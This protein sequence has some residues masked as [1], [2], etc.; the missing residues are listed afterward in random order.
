MSSVT[1][2]LQTS[3]Q[4]RRLAVWSPAVPFLLWPLWSP[5]PRSRRWALPRVPAA[6]SLWGSVS[7]ASWSGDLVWDS[8]APLGQAGA[9]PGQRGPRLFDLSPSPGVGEFTF[10]YFPEKL[11]KP[12]RLSSP[13]QTCVFTVKIFLRVRKLHQNVF[14]GKTLLCAAWPSCLAGCSGLGFVCEMCLGP[15][16]NNNHNNK[17]V[18]STYYLSV[19]L[20]VSACVML[21]PS[22]LFLWS[23][24]LPSVSCHRWR[25]WSPPRLG[26]FS[27]VTQPA[28]SRAR[29]RLQA[30]LTSEAGFLLTTVHLWGPDSC[31]GQTLDSSINILCVTSV[32]SSFLGWKWKWS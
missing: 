2:N 29:I 12:V 23:V 32:S 4:I 13:R 17:H 24:W 19:S 22:P 28:R 5:P 1:S 21:L 20:P 15:H 7:G 27:K 30:C 6:L 11:H 10:V 8:A 14:T 9:T 31:L 18:G 26:D 16:F 25:T 3:E